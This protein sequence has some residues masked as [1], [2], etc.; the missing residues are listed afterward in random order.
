MLVAGINQEATTG[1]LKLVGGALPG[2]DLGT[3]LRA[4]AAAA[5]RAALA[6]SI[7]FFAARSAALLFVLGGIEGGSTMELGRG[8]PTTF[9]SVCFVGVSMSS[10]DL[11]T[12]P[13]GGGL[14]GNESLV[15]IAEYG[16]RIEA[17]EDAGRD[18]GVCGLPLV[19]V[20]A[21]R[22]D[23][24]G[25]VAAAVASFWAALNAALLF[26]LGVI[27]GALVDATENVSLRLW[28]GTPSNVRFIFSS[29]VTVRLTDI[30]DG[31]DARPP[32]ILS[33]AAFVILGAIVGAAVDATAIVSARL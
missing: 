31:S 33:A 21:P 3:G 32:L 16:R 22:K 13:L 8:R 28:P 26:D 20:G 30:G 18:D 14:G 6:S 25:G 11:A 24:G 5:F 9:F 2:T 12:V 10:F 27:I 29:S 15:L 7:S 4:A 1:A 17:S 23:D 19:L